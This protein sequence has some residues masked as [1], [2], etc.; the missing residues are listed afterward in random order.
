MRVVNVLSACLI[1]LCC[2]G[3]PGAVPAATAAGL[4]LGAIEVVAGGG[5]G[6]G[7]LAVSVSLQPAGV[8]AGPDGALWIAD[9]QF[10][11]VRLV[12]P[13]GIIRS[14]VGSGTYGFNGSGLPA[15]RSH[16]GIVADLALDEGGRLLLVDVANR[17]VRLVD[18][19]GALQT[20]VD[21]SHPLFGTVPGTFAPASVAVGPDGT[22]HIADRGTN[23][24]WQFDAE[25][26]ASGAVTGAAGRRVAG[27]GTRGFSGDGA[28]SALGQLADPRA[29]AVGADGAIWIADTGNSR[30]RVVAPDGRLSTAATGLKP[31]DIAVG[32]AGEVFVLDALGNQVVR[33]A[34]ADSWTVVHTFAPDTEPV[35]IAAQPVKEPESKAESASTNA[36]VKLSPEPALSEAGLYQDTYIPRLTG[37]YRAE[38]IVLDE[39]G[40]EAGRAQIG[41]T[42]DFAADEFRSLK[43]NRALLE[44]I[45]KQSR[46]EMIEAGKL[47]TFVA[48]LPDRKAPVTEN[49]SFPLWHTPIVFLFALA[50][51]VTEWG[52]RRWKGMA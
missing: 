40:L 38:T 3:I 4:S 46:G 27:N 26:T 29:V 8:L 9:E 52:L 50:C 34:G 5:L 44:S 30:I 48:T 23:V 25:S 19:D 32:P 51:F 35:A 18:A 21:A 28:P 45:A 37:G 14:V 11:R 42:V 10:N 47:Q 41:W 36:A 22:I 39:N 12:A 17:Q 49:W 16:L 15:L 20:F 13:D 24:V 33:L 43:P 1:T 31:V 7:T 2:A 6:D